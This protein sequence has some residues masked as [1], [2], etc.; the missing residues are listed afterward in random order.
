MIPN[1][2]QQLIMKYKEK[3]IMIKY[4]NKI[5]WFNGQRFEFWCTLESRCD[6]VLYYK[7][8]YTLITEVKC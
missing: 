2:L 6:D 1:V 4:K 7:K 3:G 5:Y 8:N